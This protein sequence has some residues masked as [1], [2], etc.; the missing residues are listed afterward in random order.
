[1]AIEDPGPVVQRLVLGAEL[2]ELREAATITPEDAGKRLSWYGTKISKIENG[3]GKL[4]DAEAEKLLALYGASEG[5][6]DRVRQL[7]REARRRVPAARVS[8][9]AKKYVALESSASEIKVW[10]G[11][12]IPGLLQTKDYARA[13]LS[14]SVVVPS[15]EIDQMATERERRSERLTGARPPMLW[16]VLGEEAITRPVGGENV[17]R[18]QLIRLRELAELDHVT[19][20]VMPQSAGA[21]AG[22]GLAFTLLHIQGARATFAYVEGL[23]NA[24]YLPRPRHTQ[25]YGL[26]FDRLRVAA[27]SDA[28][29]LAIIERNIEKLV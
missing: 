1:M 23:T 19:L 18:G 9:W 17:L 28:Q 20:Q 8:D 12:S 27:L 7:A 16:V 24:D 14:V 4:T 25:A 26:V 21:H 13:V 2:R 10:F 6:A 11:D 5:T 29:S 22:L 15:I 3:D